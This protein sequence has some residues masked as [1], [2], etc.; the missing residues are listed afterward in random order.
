MATRHALRRIYP[1]ATSVPHGWRGTRTPTVGR[2]NHAAHRRLHRRAL[3]VASS[4]TMRFTS[5][6]AAEGEEQKRGPRKPF[7]QRHHDK[8]RGLRTVL[9]TKLSK[10]FK[11][12][13]GDEI[14]EDVVKWEQWGEPSLPAERTVRWRPWLWSWHHVG[15]LA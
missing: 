11:T 5:T 3:P 9:H 4:M 1:G 8:G 15:I 14:P 10:P 7:T 12:I 6:A 2:G 13:M